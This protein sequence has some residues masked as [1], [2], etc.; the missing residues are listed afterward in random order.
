MGTAGAAIGS[1]R[2]GQ[3]AAIGA[4]AGAGTGA[5]MGA[6]QGWDDLVLDKG[7]RLEL[8]LDRPL[9]KALNFY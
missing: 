1:T 4:A 3:D 2:S 5:M 6:L 8:Q 7:T 9:G